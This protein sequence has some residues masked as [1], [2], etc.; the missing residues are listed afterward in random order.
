M[1]FNGLGEILNKEEVKVE[2]LYVNGLIGGNKKLFFIDMDINGYEVNNLIID[3]KFVYMIVRNEN[4]FDEKNERFV[5]RRWINSSG[6][7]SSGLFEF[8]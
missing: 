2:G 1:L 8:F 3:L 5:K 6:K 4:D 7:E